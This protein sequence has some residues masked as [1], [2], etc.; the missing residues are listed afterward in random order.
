PV[1]PPPPKP[2]APPARDAQIAIEKA[3]RQKRLAD[4]REAEQ[5]RLQK[6]RDDKARLDKARDDK[7]REDKARDDRQKAERL[8]KEQAAQKEAEAE[9]D[10]LAKQREANL[11]RIRGLAG[12]TGAPTATGNDL[13]DA[14]PSAAYAGRIKARIKP[15]IVLAV[16]VPGNPVA[17]VE[18]RCGPDGT[19]IGR[20]LTKSSGNATWDDTVL[21]AIDRTEVLPR[22][23]DGRVP[24]TMT[25]VFPRRE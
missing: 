7:V 1:A 12:A 17:E 24:S 14:A 11:A 19:I 18:V 25:L 13:R 16:D 23:V 9:E 21:R 22:D 4:E 8:K 5:Q 15:N 3:E 20:K 10:R 6:A 2:A